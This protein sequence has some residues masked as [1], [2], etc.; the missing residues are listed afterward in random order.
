MDRVHFH[1]LRQLT[2]TNPKRDCVSSIRI[3][4]QKSRLS[5]TQ[6]TAN[7]RAEA[8]SERATNRAFNSLSSPSADHQ[9]PNRQIL[10][11]E[12]LR[13]AVKPSSERIDRLSDFG[14]PRLWTSDAARPSQPADLVTDMSLSRKR[15]FEI[16][17]ASP[18]HAQVD[19]PLFDGIG[20]SFDAVFLR[21]CCSC[22]RCVDPS[23]TQKTFDSADIPQNVRPKTI[24]RRD[25]GSVLIRWD[26]D[27][28][29]FDDHMSIYESSFGENNNTLLS[30]LKATRNMLDPMIGW[31]KND[32]TKNQLVV[33]YDSYMNSSS[34]LLSCLRHM[35]QYGL[36]FVK[37][38]PSDAE[39][40]TRIGN[41][42]GPLKETLYGS[43]WDV[44][45]VPSAKN[46]AYT[47]SHLGF[48]MVSPPK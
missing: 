37:S 31:D 15:D 25:D 29:G 27:I 9:D 13:Q 45:S 39:S 42:I 48:H 41:R 12:R 34:T 36:F 26:S 20:S 19:L 14:K 3:Y 46:V 4:V 32:I 47:S 23:T 21:D 17:T 22:E 30:R 28:P 10:M 7:T 44:R 2:S 1:S 16:R 24:E 5:S 18:K 11:S 33:E 8:V 35:T 6:R 43:T 40:V 38:V